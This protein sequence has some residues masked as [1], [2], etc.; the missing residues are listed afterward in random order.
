ME[1]T[2]IV[3]KH[4]IAVMA[5]V[6]LVILISAGVLYS[7][8]KT[9]SSTPAHASTNAWSKTRRVEVIDPKYQI[10]AITMAIPADWKFAGTI[11]RPPGCHG[12]GASLKYTAQSPDGVSALV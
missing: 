3:M 9:R 4:K 12:N 5:C 2:E 7:Q 11:A 6:A 10:T 1:I 8:Q